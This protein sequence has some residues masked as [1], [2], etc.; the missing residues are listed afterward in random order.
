MIASDSV[1]TYGSG[2]NKFFN[3]NRIENINAQT[4]YAT[5][6]ELSDFQE[7]TRELKQ[8]EQNSTLVEDGVQYSPHHYFNY[9]GKLFKKSPF[10]VPDAEQIQPLYGHKCD[11][12]F[13]GWRT[14]F[15]PCGHVRGQVGNRPHRHRNGQ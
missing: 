15:G 1:L 6:G 4:L 7:L 14:L 11:C 5:S 10:A 3:V 9:L 13:L 12:R 8:V 2:M